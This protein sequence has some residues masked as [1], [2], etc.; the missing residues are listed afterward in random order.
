MRPTSCSGLEPFATVAWISLTGTPRASQRLWQMCLGQWH[1]WLHALAAL[2][3]AAC[4]EASLC[5]TASLACAGVEREAGAA[6]AAPALAPRVRRKKRRMAEAVQ[7][8]A[9]LA[10]KKRALCGALHACLYAWSMPQVLRLQP[11]GRSGVALADS[12][13]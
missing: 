11:P 5:P 4:F 9:T 2:P 12:G 7:A 13:P 1:V 8:R 6:A 3:G 10:D